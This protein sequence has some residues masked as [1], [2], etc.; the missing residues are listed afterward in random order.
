VPE[1]KTKLLSQLKT[2]TQ[3]LNRQ[4]TQD[5]HKYWLKLRGQVK[6]IELLRSLLRGSLRLAVSLL[7]AH[8]AKANQQGLRTTPNK[9]KIWLELEDPQIAAAAKPEGEEIYWGDES[10]VNNQPNA[11]RGFAPRGETP[12]IKQM[13]KRFGSSV[14]SAVSNWGA[15]PVR[16][17]EGSAGLGAFHSVPG[18][19]GGL[20]WKGAKC[21]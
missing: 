8:T 9:V 14:M 18:A 3:K 12:M 20:R 13:P 2:Q 10:G 4:R 15:H 19:A 16:G 11:P 6:P 1:T 7:S 5:S 21:L 17:C